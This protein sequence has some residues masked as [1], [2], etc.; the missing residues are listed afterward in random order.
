MLIYKLYEGRGW[1]Q[2]PSR[3]LTKRIKSKVDGRYRKATYTTD[4]K[5]KR[6]IWSWL[7]R[8]PIEDGIPNANMPTE[9]GNILAGYEEYPLRRYG[10]DAIFYW[11]RIW[12]KLEDKTRKE[13]DSLGGPADCL[14]YLSF[15]SL[16]GFVLL[17]PF[18]IL[19]LVLGSWSADHAV[20]LRILWGGGAAVL[21]GF[22]WFF[23][24][25]SLDRHVSYGEYFK[26]VFDI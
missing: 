25:L 12:L 15:V 24:R 4:D 3:R 10:M 17:I 13:L 18:I 19:S 1:P 21:F 7:R 22:A 14:V 26:A 11:Y 9:L 16:F 2:G 8:F 6:E 20:D 5:E 23:Y